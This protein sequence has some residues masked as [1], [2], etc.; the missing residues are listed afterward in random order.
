MCHLER[1]ALAIARGVPPLR[2]V[3]VPS[4]ANG[5]VA[6]DAAVAVPVCACGCGGREGRSACCV[7]A[8][9]AAL[10]VVAAHMWH[11]ARPTIPAGSFCCAAAS[12]RW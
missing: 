5:R 10:G 9:V 2:S 6:T 3:C 8:A 12:K 4:D 1:F 7:A 11:S